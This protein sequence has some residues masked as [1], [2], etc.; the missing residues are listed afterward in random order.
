M[1]ALAKH[2][3]VNTETGD[4]T[5]D[6][7]P[8]GY[9]LADEPVIVTAGTNM[10]RLVTVTILAEHVTISPVHLEGTPL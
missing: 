4:L 7:V 6:G 8:F 1:T 3:E 5:I 10:A 2:I 9:Y